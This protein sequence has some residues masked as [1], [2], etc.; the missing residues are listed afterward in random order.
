VPVV[1][2]P[3]SHLCVEKNAFDDGTRRVNNEFLAT[4][5]Y[6]PFNFYNSVSLL[7]RH[8]LLFCRQLLFFLFVKCKTFGVLEFWKKEIFFG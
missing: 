8:L 5:W 6:P 7:F 2:L 3:I 1:E 4:R